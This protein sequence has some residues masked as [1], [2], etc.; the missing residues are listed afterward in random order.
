LSK[1]KEKKEGISSSTNQYIK[2]TVNVIFVPPVGLYSRRNNSS[3]SKL[4]YI[5]INT[6]RI[7]YKIIKRTDN[8]IE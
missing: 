1:E 4:D 7:I 2:T 6:E 3:S 5:T 8:I